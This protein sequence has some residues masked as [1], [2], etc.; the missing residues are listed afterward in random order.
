MEPIRTT[1]ERL[2]K[3]WQ[4]KKQKEKEDTLGEGLR[5][6][7]TKQ[8]QRHIKY[9]SLKESQV[10]LGVDSSVWLYML[11]LKKRQLLRNLN[12][13]HEPKGALTEILLQLDT[14]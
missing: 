7:L 10:I 5:K 13:I 14:N 4:G 6:F 9:Y 12:Q 11:N 8:E 1:I 2:T 3:G